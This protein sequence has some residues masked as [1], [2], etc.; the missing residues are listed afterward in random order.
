LLSILI[1]QLGLKL[2]SRRKGNRGQQVRYYSLTVEDLSFA[3][4]VL[5]HREQQRM[6]R[7]QQE[8]E[9]KEKSLRHQAKMQS[10]YGID[11]PKS[12]VVTPPIKGD[13]YPLEPPLTTEN[14]PSENQETEYKNSSSNTL[15]K[16]KPCFSLLEG[17]V[18]Q[19]QEVIKEIMVQLLA[20]TRGQ[21]IVRVLSS[22]LLDCANDESA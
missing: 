2:I 7:L 4:D 17:I 6:D 18:N 5:Q 8:L 11:P 1:N 15:E 14:N 3:I 10:L 13:I 12:S 9:R 20:S 22:Q 16:L 21:K 19:G